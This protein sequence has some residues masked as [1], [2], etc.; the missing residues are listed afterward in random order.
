MNAEKRVCVLLLC[1]LLELGTAGCPQHGA[2][3]SGVTARPIHRGPE[4]KDSA[5]TRRPTSTDYGNLRGCFSFRRRK[6]G[7][8]DSH[9]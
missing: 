2:A 6:A 4:G 1:V 7:E 5:N 9:S 8:I 3:G